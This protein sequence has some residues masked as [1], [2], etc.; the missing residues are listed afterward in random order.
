M[1]DS[2]RLDPSRGYF[3]TILLLWG[4]FWCAAATTHAAII[5]ELAIGPVTLEG[6]TYPAFIELAVGDL[7]SPFDLL[8]TDGRL[9]REDRILNRITIEPEGAATVVVHEGVWPML[10]A[11]SVRTVAVDDL[12][13]IASTAGSLAGTARWLFLMDRQLTGWPTLGQAPTT[14]DQWNGIADALGFYWGNGW[15]IDPT[16]GSASFQLADNHA[17]AQHWLGDQFSGTY[18]H[19]PVNASGQ[20]P[21]GY[22]ISPGAENPILPES[23]GYQPEPATLLVICAW[24][25][26]SRRRRTSRRAGQAL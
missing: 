13:L 16:I 4:F 7:T 17:L 6:N 26:L 14:P 2:G 8:I 24:P 19:G 1:R 12:K 25:L 5:S 18:S 11:P 10:P 21:N 3:R 22:P 15:T 20:F 23:V 9:G